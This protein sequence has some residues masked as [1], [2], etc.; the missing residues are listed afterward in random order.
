MA[1]EPL[2]DAQHNLFHYLCFVVESL[3]PL[4]SHTSR[5]NIFPL[6]SRGLDET[7]LEQVGRPVGKGLDSAL[8]S[9]VRKMWLRCS[10]GT[11][12]SGDGT[13]G[14]QVAMRPKHPP[15]RRSGEPFS[16]WRLQMED[17]NQYIPVLMRTGSLESD[18]QRPDPNSANR[19][20]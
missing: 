8:E 9:L 12:L 20:L 18:C 16:I 14:Q 7:A 6:R 3:W 5:T 1:G 19:W 11:G 17:S 2:V 4:I 10:V 15:P 13:L